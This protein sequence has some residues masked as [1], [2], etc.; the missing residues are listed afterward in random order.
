VAGAAA[1]AI[2]LTLR[3]TAHY[4]PGAE[5]DTVTYLAAAHHLRAGHGFADIGGTPLTLFPPLFPAAV[6][7]LEWLGLAPLSAARL[8]NAAMFGLLVV[9][10]AAWTRRISGSA[11]L[12]AAVA[13]NVAV[14]TPMVAMASNA[15][16]EPVGIVLVVACLALLT[17]AIRTGG[18]SSP[19]RR[20]PGGRTGR[21]WTGGSGFA[22]LA[23]LAAG[24]ACL[25]R[26]ASVVLFPVG[27]V[28]LLLRPGRWRPRIRLPA[29]FL[30]AGLLPF[31][32]W[33]ARNVAAA[34]NATG[35][36]RGTSALT[37]A[38]SLK[39]TLAAVGAWVLPGSV[40]VTAQAVVGG[41]L[42]AGV[43]GGLLVAARAERRRGR[44]VDGRV[45]GSA[46]GAAAGMAVGG[47]AGLVVGPAALAWPATAF[48]V[49][50]VGSVAWFEA[51]MA[52]DPPPRFLLPVFVP[53][54]VGAAV[55]AGQ[56]VRR[57]AWRP[58]ATGVLVTVVVAA[59][60]P[61]LGD[62]L[63]HADR[64]GLLDYSTPAWASS[65][66]LAY[67]K[68]HPL[69][70]AV[71]S[72]DPYILDLRLGIPAEP[73]P[74]R[75][76]YASSEPTRELPRFVQ[77]AA[78]AAAT[79]GLTVVWFPRSYQGYFYSLPDLERVLCLTVERHFADGDL[80]RSCPGGT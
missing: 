57:W 45:A 36:G 80:L 66:L 68:D 62:F 44:T 49:L 26:Y 18:A 64:N 3:A 51:T 13:L 58:V 21:L 31:G 41:G 34:G 54:L 55:L 52:I 40:P 61:G 1:L 46:A 11:P 17:E 25:T 47:A 4:G 71:A 6:A 30:A 59:W 9:L 29:L 12:G 74:A 72:D 20:T 60:L 70:G 8:L 19:E 50:G 27:V 2:A 24:L 63:H 79:G 35:D 43:A 73:T 38:S 75:T 33:L 14:A 32:A 76:Y 16:S 67:L 69:R 78:R 65:P 53:L 77:R 15:L 7:V 37:L 28:V 39:L 10:A 22:L 23:G 48:V 56:L 42:C 5:P